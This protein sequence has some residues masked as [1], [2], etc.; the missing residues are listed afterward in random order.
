MVQVIWLLSGLGLLLLA[1]QLSKF[2]M[3]HTMEL[4]LSPDVRVIMTCREPL[5]AGH[6]LCYPEGHTYHGVYEEWID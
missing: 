6:G 2:L 1:I 4:V 3:P 5:V